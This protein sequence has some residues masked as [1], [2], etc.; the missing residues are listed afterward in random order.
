[1]ENDRG[2]RIGIPPD[3]L[4]KLVSA[5]LSGLEG[6]AHDKIRL[7]G[8]AAGLEQHE[9]QPQLARAQLPT[10]KKHLVG[11]L[12]PLVLQE[13]GVDP[14]ISP[15]AAVLGLVGPW[16]FAS[17]SAFSTLRE[18]AL[19]RHRNFL[20]ASGKG[21]MENNS[22]SP[23]KGTAAGAPGQDVTSFAGVPLPVP[24]KPKRAPPEIT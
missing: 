6:Y 21:S 2:L 8:A 3:L 7:V 23:G 24:L 4:S 1:M 13:W 9:I 14:E 5:G 16:M 11:D 19:E 18:L 20:A 12:A 17:W 15:T 10:D 22:P